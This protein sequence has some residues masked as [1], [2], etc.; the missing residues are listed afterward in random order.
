MPWVRRELV[1]DSYGKGRVFLAGDSV[2]MMSP[3]GGFGMNTGI[4]DAVDL[5]WKLAAALEGWGGPGLLASYEIERRPVGLRNVAE[6]AGNLGR[7]LSP[8]RNR[9]I[10]DDTPEGAA[11]RAS[12]GEEFAAA[13][14]REWFTLGMHLGYRYDPSP[15][16]WPDGTPAP[17][18]DPT[19]YV[20]TAR[21]GSR[22]PHVWLDDGR[23]TLDL[24]GSGFVLLRLGKAAPEAA[25]LVAAAE[26]RG[27]P[28]T[29]EALDQPAVTAAYEK[30]LVLVRPDGHVAWRSDALPA[31]PLEL[32][33]RVRGAAAA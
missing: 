28:L 13:M 8:D 27:V 29:V 1:A 6:A 16:C 22:A 23:S 32:V 17:P 30:S 33:D 10:L 4:A 21:P 26:T 3:T 24:F 11:L 14:R 12:L 2:H 20:Q 7:M 18:D 31:D 15:I 5:S 19:D 25:A 9:A